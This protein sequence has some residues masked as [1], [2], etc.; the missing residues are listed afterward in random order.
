MDSTF[1]AQCLLVLLRRNADTVTYSSAILRLLCFPVNICRKGLSVTILKY[2]YITAFICMQF[3]TVN[4]I[5]YWS[6]KHPEQ[7]TCNSNTIHTYNNRSDTSILT[8]YSNCQH[9]ICFSI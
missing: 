5:N 3:D 1:S 4:P 8:L 2:G 9:I 7:I 6:F